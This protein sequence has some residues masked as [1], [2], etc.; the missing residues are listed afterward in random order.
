M[1][2]IPPPRGTSQRGLG[3]LD[4]L[5][6]A[7]HNFDTGSSALTLPRSCT[8]YACRAALKQLADAVQDGD[9]MTRV[10]WTMIKDKLI[11][12]YL[13]LPIEYY[14]LGLPNRDRTNDQVRL[15]RRPSFLLQ[16]LSPAPQPFSL[17]PFL[18]P[19]RRRIL[20]GIPW[21]SPRLHDRSPQSVRPGLA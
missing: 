13:D 18:L 6:W 16:A 14:D 5:C 10:I 7:E 12:P 1:L 8:P 11:K 3:L 4:R 21:P 15:R 2:R 19:E 17:L 9:E 20:S